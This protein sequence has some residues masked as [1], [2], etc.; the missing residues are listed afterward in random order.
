MHTR[1]VLGIFVAAAVLAGCGGAQSTAPLPAQSTTLTQKKK[2]TSQYI[3]HV[4]VLIQENRSFDDFFATFPGADGTKTGKRGSKTV[5]LVEVALKGGCD[6]LHARGNFLSDYA[7]GKMNGFGAGAIQCKKGNPYQYVNPAQVASYWD[8]AKTY[9][10][11]D[12]MFQTQGSGS[13]TGHQDLIRG[14]TTIDENQTTSLV[15]FPTGIP[16]GCD[17]PPATVTSLLVKTASGLKKEPNQ[18][19]FP[20]TNKFPASGAYYATLRD[21]LDAKSVSWKYYVPAIAAKSSGNLWNAF[22]IIAPVRYGSE[23][24]SNISSPNT[25]FFKD[26]TNGNLPSMSWLIPLGPNSDHPADKADDGPSW[27]ASVVNAVGKSQYWSTTAIVVVW[28][29]WGG[30]YDHVPPPFFDNWGG[31]GFRVPL[32][33][34]SPY[35]KETTPGTPGYISKTQYEFGSILKFVEQN[36]G[37]GSLGTTDLRATSIVDSFDFTQKPRAFISIPSSKSLDYFE[38]EPPSNEPIDTE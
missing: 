15:D 30:F 20:C 8:I 14:S 22:D 26:V 4:I 36:W 12:H 7:A 32:L 33:I 25:N 23:W 9:V 11:G 29:D 18:G 31:L 38:H 37:L 24:T 16:W 27:V 34:V 19:P 13:F 3:S 28:D 17:A 10:L 2:H 35:A 5:K 6:F 21:L 1:S